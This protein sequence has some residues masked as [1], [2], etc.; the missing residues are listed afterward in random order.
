MRTVNSTVWEERLDR[1]LAEPEQC[2]VEWK[3]NMA[4]AERI[5]EY[6]SAMA[7]SA[8]LEGRSHGYVVWGIDDVSREPVGTTFEPRTAK[9]A[10]NQAL[11]LWLSS[12]LRPA[13][14]FEF[15]SIDYR[16]FRLV[17]LSVPRATH[18]PV[19][20]KDFEYLRVDSH[21]VKAN[22]HQERLRLLWQRLSQ[23]MSQEW[24]GEAVTQDW[25]LLEPA[26]LQ[27]GR[28][29]F[30]RKHPRLAQEVTGWSDERFLSEL[31]VSRDGHLT[32]AALLLFG[33]P[34][35]AVW[36]GGPSPR[37]TWKLQDAEGA[38]L[39]YMH[40]ELPFVLT[41]DQLINR[42]RRLTVRILP[43]RQ[44]A[45]LEL[46]NYDDWVIREA[47]L[48]CIAH[49][50]YVQGGRI[51]VTERPDTLDF[52]NYGGFLPGD[53]DRVLSGEFVEG[54]YR[55]PCLADAMLK[56]DLIDTAGT[57][58]KRMYR[59][60]RERYFPMPDYA[61][62]EAPATVH[63]RLYG[64]EID[65]AFTSALF[66]S[67]DLSQVEVIGLDRVQKKQP[68]NPEVAKRLRQMGLIEGRGEK[69]WISARVAQI[70]GQ[71]VQYTLQRGLDAQHYKGLVLGLLKVGPQPRQKIDALLLEKLPDAIAPEKRKTYIKNLLR[72]MAGRDESIETDGARTRAAKWRLK[73]PGGIG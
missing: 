72:D 20:F 37:L 16:G 66:Q 22:R 49:Q 10:G 33:R 69:L 4:D 28:S 21:V 7:N 12:C 27:A 35:A 60:Q 29:G 36:L 55:N 67:T 5:G 1:W 47:L 8:A 25:S 44:L 24:S 17:V 59:R 50:D 57:G 9:A 41:A 13:V 3:R 46:S 45:P 56:I 18:T 32:R 70:T 31:R 14:P 40:L 38:D 51:I 53:V 52:F 64:R 26:A 30:I 11:M 34:A 65:R 61:M 15:D 23:S 68:I 19:S 62:G 2:C 71:E 43:P 54:R 6:L 42:I 63:M 48:N 39:D 58:I 73:R